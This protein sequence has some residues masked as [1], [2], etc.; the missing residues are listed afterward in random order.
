MIKGFEEPGGRFRT[1]AGT[2]TT[3]LIEVSQAARNRDRGER[4]LPGPGKFSDVP[5]SAI[6]DETKPAL[7]YRFFRNPGNAP[8]APVQ[9][10]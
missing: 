9:I 2:S 5:S 6:L 4:P 10:Y 8:V 1:I 7:K 3:L